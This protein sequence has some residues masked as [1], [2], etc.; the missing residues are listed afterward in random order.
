MDCHVIEL[1]LVPYHFG[2]IDDA[3][4]RAVEEHLVGCT[5]C[6]RD[7]IAL[8]REMETSEA[9][10]SPTAKSRL[11]QAVSREVE[12]PRLTW[13]WWERPLA[14]AFAGAAVLTAMVMVHEL[15]SSQGSAPHAFVTP[16]MR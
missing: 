15:A 14:V 7:F 10:P 16:S 9:I 12:R 8:K 11:R 4:R 6:L 3:A 5:Q 2:Q 1:D 13:S